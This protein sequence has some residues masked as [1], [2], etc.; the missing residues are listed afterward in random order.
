MELAGKFLTIVWTHMSLANL[1]VGLALGA[2]LGW[3][4]HFFETQRA[5]KVH[6]A[7]EA[8]LRATIAAQDA[9]LGSMSTAV[10][11]VGQELVSKNQEL[12]REVVDLRLEVV[13]LQGEACRQEE[14]QGFLAWLLRR[15]QPALPAGQ[16]SHDP[17]LLPAATGVTT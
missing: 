15:R 10:A 5:R 14:R 1:L 7:V 8:R 9:R 11:Q 13:R 6:K 4:K 16:R 3:L 2:V 12:Q 17:L